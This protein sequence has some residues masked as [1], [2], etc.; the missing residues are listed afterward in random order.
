[1][2]GKRSNLYNYADDNT[3]SATDSK[4]ENVIESLTHESNF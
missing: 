4:I 3:L 2:F 1:M